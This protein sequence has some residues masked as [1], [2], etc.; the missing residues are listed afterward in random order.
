MTVKEL[1]TELKKFE[2]EATLMVS[3]DEELNSLFMGYEVATLEDETN[4]GRNIVVLYPLSTTE[5]F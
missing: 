1:I 4:N 2:Q 5:A 3:S